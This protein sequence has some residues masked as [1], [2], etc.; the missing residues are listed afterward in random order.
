MILGLNTLD[1][2]LIFLGYVLIFS[3]AKLSAHAIERNGGN[4]NK[5]VVVMEC[6]LLKILLS[7]GYFVTLEGTLNQLWTQLKKHR[8]MLLSFMIPSGLYMCVDA[9]NLI[10]LQTIDPR[11]LTMLGSLKIVCMGV[12][13][14][15]FFQKRLSLLQWAGLCFI[16]IG[17]A[18]DQFAAMLLQEAD[19]QN[20]GS[21]PL[22][23]GGSIEAATTYVVSP[24]FARV[25][26]MIEIILVVL[27]A[28]YFELL[29]KRNYNLSINVQNFYLYTNNLIL[30]A[31][32]QFV[33]YFFQL[34]PQSVVSHHHSGG[35]GSSGEK[36][37]IATLGGRSDAS[38]SSTTI[39]EGTGEGGGTYNSLATWMLDYDW[40]AYVL[41]LSLSL[42]GILTSIFMKRLDSVRKTIAMAC[43]MAS[44]AALGFLVL[45]IPLRG[46]AIVASC[47]VAGGVYFYSIGTGKSTETKCKKFAV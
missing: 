34:G 1:K 42:G 37:A 44:D 45:N 43:Q 23:D 4:L 20:G 33:L 7:V 5:F 11:T 28:V 39:K 38:S 6:T 19:P 9:I 14:S 26:V 13:W 29:V 3:I 36:A 47:I 24:S 40:K 22:Q 21:T 12:V 8:R 2:Q 41:V 30:G 18:L 32:Y 16:T 10:A 17:C 31:M 25:L 46:F 35:A 27:A 15:I